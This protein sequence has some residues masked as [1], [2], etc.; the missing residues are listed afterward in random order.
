MS[1]DGVRRRIQLHQ[2]VIRNATRLNC[3]HDSRASIP[4]RPPLVHQQN[5][6]GHREIHHRN[7]ASTTA[8][9]R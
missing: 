8:I 2:V 3:I 5:S 4:S 9:D 7:S 6:S 1:A